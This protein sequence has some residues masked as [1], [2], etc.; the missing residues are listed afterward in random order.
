VPANNTARQFHPALGEDLPLGFI[1][2]GVIGMRVQAE[3][4]SAPR[5][6]TPTQVRA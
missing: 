5:A 6:D 4:P 3:V 1:N 2:H